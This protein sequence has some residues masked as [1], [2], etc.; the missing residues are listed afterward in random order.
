M[1]EKRQRWRQKLI[2]NTFS[3]YFSL[4]HS[5]KV[6]RA[7]S[8]FFS[9]T[10]NITLSI[11]PHFFHTYTNTHSLFYTRTRAN[12][13]FIFRAHSHTRTFTHVY[14][15]THVHPP[16]THT[17]NKHTISFRPSHFQLHSLSRTFTNTQSTLSLSHT[18]THHYSITQQYTAKVQAHCRKINN[19]S[20]FL[21]VKFK[22]VHD[23]FNLI[24]E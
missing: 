12:C 6:K 13:S 3:S 8:A 16:P 17:S 21:L 7:N 11:L 18:H 14:T 10:T 22:S 15:H 19:A 2:L 1:R 24:R 23:V 20:L 4:F 5:E 9:F